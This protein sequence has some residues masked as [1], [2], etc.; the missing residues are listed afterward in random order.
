MLRAS[1]DTFGLP[2]VLLRCVKSKLTLYLVRSQVRLLWLFEVY[3]ACRHCCSVST[4]TTAEG[5][6]W[7]VGGVFAATRSVYSHR[8]IHF[9]LVWMK[10]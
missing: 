4:G 7:T 1:S 8:V 10:K 5:A 2:L 6:L 3:D 9:G